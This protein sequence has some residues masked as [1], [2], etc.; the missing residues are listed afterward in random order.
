MTRRRIEHTTILGRLIWSA[1]AYGAIGEERTDMRCGLLLVAMLVV[2][3][4]IPQPT[5]G[6]N[7]G[8][9]DAVFMLVS[10][11]YTGDTFHGHY[12][13]VAIGT[14][15]FISDDG[16]A[17]TNSHVVYLAQHNPDS[18]RLVAVVGKELFSVQT[19]CASPVSVDPG[20][21]AAEAS[22]LTRD[23]A[24]VKVVPFNLSTTDAWGYKEGA[25]FVTL[26]EVHRGPLPRF[27]V[28]TLG[29]RPQVGDKVRIVGYGFQSILI[30]AHQWTADGTVTSL[31]RL[32]DGTPA[33]L[34]ESTLRPQKGN[35]GSPVL[36]ED[37]H[38][39]GL[40]TWTLVSHAD[41]SLAQA[42]P[43]FEHP[44]GM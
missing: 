6:Q 3:L 12:Q 25:K 13:S 10:V 28:L 43:A 2:G 38:V 26:A 15:F 33:F 39:V 9:L 30:H 42:N 14:A 31:G 19:I 20:Q 35:S 16:T 36:N 17:I 7:S 11:K 41:L 32:T 22:K 23:V 34:I 37:D 29:N 8:T 1:V 24:L 44:C 18:Y 40:W 21:P 27:Q 4:T 5:R